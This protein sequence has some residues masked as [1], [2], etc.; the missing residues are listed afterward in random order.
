MQ[1]LKAL[2]LNMLNNLN[3][4]KMKYKLILLIAM[5]ILQMHIY[6]LFAQRDPHKEILVFFNEGVKRETRYENGVETMRS[7]VKSDGLRYAL[8]REVCNCRLWSKIKSK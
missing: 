5:A 4:N 7:A 6:T 1:F 2:N 3:E 8:N